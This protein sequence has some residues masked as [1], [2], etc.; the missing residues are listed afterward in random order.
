MLNLLLQT[1]IE[2]QPDDWDISRFSRLASFLAGLRDKDGGLAF[3]VTARN[4]V[5]LTRRRLPLPLIP[6]HLAVWTLITL[7]R[8]RSTGGLRA[9]FGGFVEGM[10]E[11]AGERRPMRWRTVWRLTRLGRPPVI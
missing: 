1:T 7:L 5:W 8:T 10:R 9:W 11:P 6:V 3:R 4:R 2:E